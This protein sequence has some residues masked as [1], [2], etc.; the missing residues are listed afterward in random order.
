MPVLVE[1]W[2]KSRV[3]KWALSWNGNSRL[4]GRAA[5]RRGGFWPV[6]RSNHCTLL[7]SL[8]FAS[9]RFGWPGSFCCLSFLRCFPLPERMGR[10]SAWLSLLFIFK[11]LHWE[12]LPIL[13]S[14]RSL[15]YMG[16]LQIPLL[17]AATGKYTL[18]GLYMARTL[19]P[20]LCAEHGRLPEGCCT[21]GGV[22]RMNR[23]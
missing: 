21:H 16:S 1:R 8:L 6:F 13:S 11:I 14:F 10:F 12:I 19:S 7:E 18:P 23:H 3:I 4:L 9:Y 20:A 17:R 22:W 2:S 5:D 15:L